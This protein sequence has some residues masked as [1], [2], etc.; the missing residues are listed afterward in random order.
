MNREQTG[1][2][3]VLETVHGSRLYGLA[4]PDSDYDTY[5]VVDGGPTTQHVSGNRDILQ[6]ALDD[7]L[8]FCY[9]GSHQALEAL[10]S[11]IKTVCDP[12]WIAMFSGVQPDMVSAT[13]RYVGAIANMGTRH[14]KT[15]IGDYSQISFKHRRH[16]LRLAKNLD[17]LYR[18]GRFNPVCPPPMVEWLN[19]TAAGSRD[20]FV[21]ELAATCPAEL[22]NLPF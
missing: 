16:M 14:G 6:V 20:M 18:Y 7:F 17:C 15:R 19:A 10:W 1:R 21:A 9:E 5:R 4:G 13:S 12:R 11:P 3:M 8:R 2:T 22:E